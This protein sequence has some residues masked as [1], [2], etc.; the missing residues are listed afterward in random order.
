MIR[1]YSGCFLKIPLPHCGHTDSTCQHNWRHFGLS[2]GPMT[3][4]SLSTLACSPP[5]DTEGD[6]V[7]RMRPHFKVFTYDV[8][9][10]GKRW[11][12]FV[13]VVSS[14]LGC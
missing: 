8:L 13:S 9:L 6:A 2:L 14:T 5:K 3:P 7:V 12:R 1:E 10:V 11:A 4:H